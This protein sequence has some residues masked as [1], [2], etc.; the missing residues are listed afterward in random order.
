MKRFKKLL[1]ATGIVLVVVIAVI[2]ITQLTS[3]SRYIT[4]DFLALC[5]MLVLSIAILAGVI[6]F[7][8][9]DIRKMLR[10]RKKALNTLHMMSQTLY[11]WKKDDA[12]E[13]TTITKNE[14]T[15]KVIPHNIRNK[16]CRIAFEY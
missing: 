8:I 14:A 5:G 2:L 11:S 15:I 3:L 16:I 7:V 10:R 4:P 12:P 13:E 6:A 1:I 9:C